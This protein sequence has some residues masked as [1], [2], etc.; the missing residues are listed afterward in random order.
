MNLHHAV[1]IGIDAPCVLGARGRADS[2]DE[3]A[4]G[5]FVVLCFSRSCL[6]QRAESLDAAAPGDCIIVSPAEGDVTLFCEDGSAVCGD[7]VVVASRTLRAYLR[8]LNLPVNEVLRIGQTEH[9]RNYAT[10][11][12]WEIQERALYW[13]IKASIIIESMLL[14]LSRS[15]HMFANT[16]IQKY[17]RAM[18]ELRDAMRL[19]LAE[20]WTIRTMAERVSLSNSRFSVVYKQLYGVSPA[21]DLIAMRVEKARALLQSGR[22]PIR[23][24]AAECGFR[25]EFYFSKI[26]KRRIGQTPGR[27]RMD[28]RK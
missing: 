17:G 2:A 25:N 9:L 24:V 3:D 16:A 5:A 15:Y 4:R 27:F 13:D 10:N 19:N 14:Y 8:A 21:E 20:P 12:R 28:A 23:V 18:R 7:W 6:V 11:I 26:F 22:Q 1:R